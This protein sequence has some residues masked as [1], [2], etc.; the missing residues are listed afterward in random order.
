[1]GGAALLKSGPALVARADR[2]RGSDGER[3]R[4]SPILRQ[5]RL[6]IR[7]VA[8]T[9]GAQQRLAVERHA[10]ELQRH[11]PSIPLPLSLSLSLSLSLLDRQD[12]VVGPRIGTKDP[13]RLM[14]AVRQADA[15]RIEE[16]A[17]AQPPD[18]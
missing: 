6:G 13:I 3:P 12:G 11:R 15:A 4:S 7:P 1:M 18:L 17:P 10:P 2:R 9:I 16:K 5:R 8:G 14:M